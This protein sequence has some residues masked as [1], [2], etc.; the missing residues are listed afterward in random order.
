MNQGA[1]FLSDLR[2]AARQ[3]PV[4]AALIG[5]GAIWWLAGRTSWREVELPTPDMSGVRDAARSAGDKAREWRDTMADTG[6]QAW[7]R[8]S[9]TMA[10]A[11]EAATRAASTMQDRGTSALSDARERLAELF[12]EQPLMLGAVGVAVGAAIAAALPETELESAY[13]GEASDQVKSAL[14]E[15]ASNEA[16]RASTAAGKAADAAA[17]EARRQGLTPD[18][19]RAAAKEIPSKLGRVAEAAGATLED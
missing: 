9:R 2:E 7:S 13:L 5:V 18:Q 10:D 1:G 8:G 6:A 4:S 3:N 17:S 12:E 11:T 19:I 16:E 15:M 14:G